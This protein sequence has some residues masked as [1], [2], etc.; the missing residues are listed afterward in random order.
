[1][2]PKVF[3]L[4]PHPIVVL[5]AQGFE[6]TYLPVGT[7]ARVDVANSVEIG[8]RLGVSVWV[9][10]PGE[11]VGLPEPEADTTIIVSG[12]VL[13]ALASEGSTRKDVV[14]PGTGPNDGAI[15]NE[16]G[17]IVAVTR[18]KGLK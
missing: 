7:P 17:H 9:D 15:R 12:F 13:A 18:L 1:M 3:N 6:T 11:V 4:T 14:A 10:L 5:D 2:S 16:K 8:G